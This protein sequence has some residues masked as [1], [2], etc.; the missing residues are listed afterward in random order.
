MNKR[1]V[2]VCFAGTLLILGSSVVAAAGRVVVVGDDWPLS[3]T[4][5]TEPNDG[6]VLAENAAAW[7]TNGAPGRFLAYSNNQALTGSSLA[8]AMQTAGHDWEV[9]SSGDVSLATLLTYD[10]VFLAALA[11]D[12]ATLTA[13]VEQGGNVYLALG[14][15][16]GGAPAEAARYNPFL[17]PLGFRAGTAY[18]GIAANVAVSG[19]A[20]L[21][22][23]VDHLRSWGSQTITD[24]VAND[25]AVLVLSDSLLYIGI[26]EQRCTLPGD[27]NCDCAVNLVDLATLLA[28][29]GTAT[30]AQREQG[31]VDGDGDIDLADLALLLANFG[32]TCA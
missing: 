28:N 10:A 22:A 21:L 12:T 5:F 6:A 19:T 20:P 24:L 9:R 27:T 1:A 16:A 32:L 7:F 15:G 13:Y 29:F 23:G 17:E 2:E 8:A 4:G 26:Y 11:I 14:T 18:N 3:N 25:D 30:G 31:E